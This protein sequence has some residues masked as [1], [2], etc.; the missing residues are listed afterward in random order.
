[1]ISSAGSL[2]VKDFLSLFTKSIGATDGLN[3]SGLKTF[4]M[5]D[6][7]DAISEESD[8][9]FIRRSAFLRGRMTH[10]AC[11]TAFA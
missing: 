1:M 10:I 3:E 5:R 7:S 2:L 4:L 9:K 6:E 11:I 8:L